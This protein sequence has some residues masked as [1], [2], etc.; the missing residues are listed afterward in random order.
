M[1]LRH[2][3]QTAQATIGPADNLLYHQPIHSQTETGANPMLLKEDAQAILDDIARGWNIIKPA[4]EKLAPAAALVVPELDPLAADV[5]ALEG[6]ARAVIAEMVGLVKHIS[7]A[8][9]AAAPAPA[10]PPAPAEPAPSPV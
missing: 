5:M 1:R 6:P 7:S 8:A 3:H 9:P 4:V 10:A 2:R